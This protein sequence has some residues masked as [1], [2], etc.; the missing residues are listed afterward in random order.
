MDRT[1]AK[2]GRQQQLP[3]PAVTWKIEP[4]SPE[5]RHPT[6]VTA[7]GA[8]LAVIGGVV[9]WQG[10]ASQPPDTTQISE[11]TASMSDALPADGM[12]VTGSLPT[13]HHIDPA[14]CTSLALDRK[15]NRT[16]RRPCPPDGIAL[17]LD[18][19][20]QREDLAILA[21]DFTSPD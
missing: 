16:L 2:G 7:I 14:T 5:V 8:A 4:L 18:G 1:A 20:M 6:A 21:T 17:R 12:L 15:T 13:I 9:L 11:V 19:D 10:I 3:A